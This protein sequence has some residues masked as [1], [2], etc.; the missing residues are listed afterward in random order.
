MH[1]SSKY[2]L[3]ITAETRHREVSGVPRGIL[4]S[5]VLSSETALTEHTYSLDLRTRYP[6]SLQRFMA[7][8][9]QSS[10]DSLGDS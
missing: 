2:Q 10:T 6:L 8:Q 7:R 4:Y 5:S 1:S 3:R 9:S